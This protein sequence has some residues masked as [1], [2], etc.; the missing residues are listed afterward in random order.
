MELEQRLRHLGREPHQARQN[1]HRLAL[2]ETPKMEVTEII[3]A[4]AS[5]LKQRQNVH[6]LALGETPEME[7]TEIIET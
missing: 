6:C 4:K 1:V 7:V 3:F 5:R 2:G